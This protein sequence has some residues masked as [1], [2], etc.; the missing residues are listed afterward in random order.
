MVAYV[1]WHGGGGVDENITDNV[2]MERGLQKFGLFWVKS[3]IYFK[4]LDK[5]FI[6]LIYLYMSTILYL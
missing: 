6:F 4:F 2:V 3:K 5:I 1:W